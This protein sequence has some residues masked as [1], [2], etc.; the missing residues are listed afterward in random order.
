METEGQN[1]LSDPTFDTP[2]FD[3]ALGRFRR[4]LKSE[5]GPT[6]LF[7]VFREDVSTWGCTDWIREPVPAENSNLAFAYYEFGRHQG[8]GVTLSCLCDVDGRAACFVWVPKDQSEAADRFQAPCLKLSVHRGPIG[9]CRNG[10]SVRSYVSW[11]YRRW[12]N[13]K[14]VGFNDDLPSR[15]EAVQRVAT[16]AVT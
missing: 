6:D 4:F 8:L 12:R 5:G 10:V 13:Q 3:E 14:W 7:W 15:R 1:S 9:P 2:P 16:G 11:Q